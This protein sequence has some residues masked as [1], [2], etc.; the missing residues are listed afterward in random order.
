LAGIVAPIDDKFTE[1]LSF[2]T[3]GRW[4]TEGL[5]RIQDKFQAGTFKEHIIDKSLYYD[6]SFTAFNSFQANIFVILTMNVIIMALTIYQLYRKDS[7][8]S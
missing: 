7:I 8:P 2:L 5:A 1:I 4:G 6:N 3:L